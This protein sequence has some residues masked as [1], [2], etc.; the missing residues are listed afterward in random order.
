LLNY[1]RC[2]L[3]RLER[4][5]PGSK[6]PPVKVNVVQIGVEVCESY[7]RDH[8]LEAARGWDALTLL[9]AAVPWVLSL[10]R[11]G[12]VPSQAGPDLDSAVEDSA[13][14]RGRP[15]QPSS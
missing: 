14:A 3:V 9:R 11:Y 2:E 7:V 1:L 8:D 12:P 13:R 4:T 6:F 5:W 10:A 15:R